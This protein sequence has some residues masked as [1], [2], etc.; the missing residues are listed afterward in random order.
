MY[1]WEISDTDAKNEYVF[2]IEKQISESE[3]IVSN[4]V[5]MH[6]NDDGT[7]D[8]VYIDSDGDGLPDVYE[9]E[10][11]TDILNPDTDGDGLPDGY[12][13]FTLETNPLKSDTDDNGVLDGN[14]DFDGDG[15]INLQEYLL[16]TNP[17][18]FD[19][20]NDGFSDNYEVTHKMN[21]LVYNE[22]LTDNSI[23]ADI[24]D[25]TV[26]DLEILNMDEYYPLEIEFNDENT[27]VT[28]IS[29]VFSDVIVKSPIE[30]IYSIYNVKSLLGLNNP[31][32]LQNF[33]IHYELHFVN[34]SLINLI[35]SKD[36]QKYL[37]L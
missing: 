10:L 14:E 23:I 4:D 25:N 17:F 15:L 22:I 37:H 30:A 29:G 24:N 8:F 35:P 28:S 1:I 26:N 7:Y 20:D 32:S 11:G 34:L 2:V 36:F 12:E 27:Q 6:L 33:H 21:P 3:T 18:A 5:V 31:E 16:G 9:L 19:T 13:Y